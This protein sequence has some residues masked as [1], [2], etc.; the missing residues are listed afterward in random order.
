[1]GWK[2]GRGCQGAGPN[3]ERGDVSCFALADGLIVRIAQEA[4]VSG[5]WM[6]LLLLVPL[7]DCDTV[8]VC[9]P[10]FRQALA[11]WVD[12]RT[13]QGHAIAVVS[14]GGNEGEIRRRVRAA[15]G[16]QEPRF[17]LLVGDAEVPSTEPSPARAVRVP[18]HWAK[19]KV[20]V[21]WGSEPHIGTDNWYGD[22]D[23][24]G[25]PE[26]AV[27]RLTADTAEELAG[28][29]EKIIAYEQSDDFGP[30]R[31]KVNVVAGVGGFGRLTDLVLESTARFF[32]ARSIPADCDVSITYGSW[33][34][35]Y[36][37]DPRQFQRVTLERL[38]EGCRYW[39]YIGHGSPFGLD[40]IRVPGG[41]YPILDNADTAKLDCGGR[42]A[43]AVLLA[44]YTGAFDARED[45]LAEAMLRQQGGPVAVVAASRVAMPYAMTVLVLAL[46]EEGFNGPAETLGEV[47]LRAK[48]S[49]VESPHGPTPWRSMLDQ[50]AR[51]LSPAPGDLAAERAE[52]I[53]LFNL[54]G[55]PLLRLPRA[56]KVRL[57]APGSISPGQ[58]LQVEGSCPIDGTATVELVV[59]RDRLGF[60]YSARPRYLES[61]EVLD[62]FRQTYRRANGRQLASVVVPVRDGT[63]SAALAV[64]KD[65][66]GPCHLRAFVEGAKGFA[67]GAADVAVKPLAMVRSETDRPLR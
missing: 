8:V 61:A 20:N 45:C 19:A 57:V 64:P 9:P 53:L 55:D 14:N 2:F 10:A 16:R 28:M 58:V 46:A 26:A 40:S 43:I 11:P 56:E 27:G 65:A 35:P 5:P 7:A 54:L 34:S 18:V 60:A 66:Q 30:W 37:P 23:A 59:P 6:A 12:Y 33:R 3:A 17:V 41:E 50:V 49:L 13:R 15:A 47:V 48:R 4:R 25:V 63:F 52:H 24:D 62:A 1:M 22:F 44:C 21:R 29:V 42:P 32:L 38:N 36:C 51:L 39:L 67:G 31:R